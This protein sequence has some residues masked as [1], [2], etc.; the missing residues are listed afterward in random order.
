VRSIATQK[1][2]AYLLTIILGHFHY[3]EAPSQ[4]VRPHHQGS[5]IGH[6]CVNMSGLASHLEGKGL[7][8]EAAERLA[9]ALKKAKPD[10]DEDALQVR[11]PP[12]A[13]PEPRANQGARPP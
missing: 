8:P 9:E 6:L 12:A 3:K 11:A 4:V 13:I 2:A 7:A 1:S 5:R 10:A